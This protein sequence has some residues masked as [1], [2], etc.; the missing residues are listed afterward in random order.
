MHDRDLTADADD[1]LA[2]ASE[3]ARVLSALD[4][5]APTMREVVLLAATTDLDYQAMAEVLG[6]PIGTIRSRLS[7]GR[8]KL[9]ELL[10]PIDDAATPSRHVVPQ[11]RRAE[12]MSDG[13]SATPAGSAQSRTPDRDAAILIAPRPPLD[14]AIALPETSRDFSSHQRTIRF[15][16]RYRW[17]T[18]VAAVTV[19]TVFIVLQLL[20]TT[21]N[22]SDLGLEVSSAATLSLPA[23]SHPYDNALTFTYLPPGVLR[24]ET[25][26]HN[27]TTDPRQ[28]TSRRTAGEPPARERASA[29]GFQLLDGE[30][31]AG[32]SLSCRATE[33]LRPRCGS[34]ATSR[35]W[36]PWSE[37][38]RSPTPPTSA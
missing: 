38:R 12:V 18:L 2:A 14:Q 5:L 30:R 20:P 19:M 6:V 23:T 35:R 29:S 24:G 13:R 10:G 36:W 37:A 11:A 22:Y 1:R 27:K 4:T 34:T 26:L 21:S 7:R 33:P 9:R 15:A 28:F 25:T 31:R 32:R 3:R 16:R 17:P 8:R